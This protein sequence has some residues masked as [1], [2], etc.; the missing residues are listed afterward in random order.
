MKK[1]TVVIFG[2]LL[3]AGIVEAGDYARKVETRCGWF[4]NPS[5]AN[6]WLADRDGEWTIA[7]QG[8]YQL[9]NDWDWPEYKES[10]WIHT[11]AG[12]YGYGCACFKV[13]TNKKEK[14][15]IH[16]YSSN[17]K[18]LS[19]CRKDPALKEPTVED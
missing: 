3:F 17:A 2:V 10:E 16:I 8:G 9:E 15:I 19:V 5:P 1:I 18:P 14:E 6:M 13:T 7:I 12:S 11:N 4:S